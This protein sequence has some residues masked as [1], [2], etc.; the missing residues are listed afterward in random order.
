MALPV[1]QLWDETMA[2]VRRESALL[3]PLALGTLAL[4]QAVMELAAAGAD[5]KHSAVLM[6]AIGMLG[7]AAV[8]IG[9]LAIQALALIPNLSVADALRTGLRRLPRIILLALIM[10]LFLLLLALPLAGWLVSQGIDPSQPGT[11]LPPGAALY[12]MGLLAVVTWI[13]VKLYLVAPII[14]ARDAPLAEAVR[15]SFSRMRGNSAVIFGV[16][17]LFLLVG[18]VLQAATEVVIGSVFGLISRMAGTA[19]LDT[20][21]VALGVGMASAAVGLV[22]SAFGARVYKHLAG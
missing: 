7:M 2:F 16:S 14:V 12:V 1:S 18:F 21:M 8:L 5:A 19:H 9:Q 13:G 3:V 4:G 15:E 20:V 22:T 17:M 11:K 6:G 10:A